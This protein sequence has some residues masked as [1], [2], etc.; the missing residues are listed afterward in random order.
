MDGINL[1]TQGNTRGCEGIVFRDASVNGW[2]FTNSYV[3]GFQNAIVLDNTG[4]PVETANNVLLRNVTLDSLPTGVS[5]GFYS[6]LVNTNIQLK[7]V[8]IDLNTIGADDDGDYPIWFDN[9]VDGVTMD[10]VRLHESD[11]YF[12]WFRVLPVMYP[13]IMRYWRIRYPACMVVRSLSVLKA[14]PAMSISVIPY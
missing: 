9:T 2:T 8:V 14:L 7:Q 12:I 1:S 10:T 13:L 3:S 4:G 11:I 5:M 6:D